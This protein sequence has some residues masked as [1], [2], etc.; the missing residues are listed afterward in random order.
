MPKQVKSGPELSKYLI[1]KPKTLE[2]TVITIGMK[3]EKESNEEEKK[4]SEEIV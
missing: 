4:S 1:M 2:F 3:E